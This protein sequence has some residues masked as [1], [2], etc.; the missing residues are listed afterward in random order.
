MSDLSCRQYRK[1]TLI[2]R[3]GPEIVGSDLICL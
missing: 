1:Q 2:D 3:Y